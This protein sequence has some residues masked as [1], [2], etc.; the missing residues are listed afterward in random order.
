M[1]EDVKVVVSLLQCSV[2]LRVGPESGAWEVVEQDLVVLDMLLNLEELLVVHNVGIAHLVGLV[3]GHVLRCRTSRV[4]LC[5]GC[6]RAA[7]TG[8]LGDNICCKL[9]SEG[10]WVLVL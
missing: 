10:L 5:V 2:F 9:G 7:T 8:S 3:L 1:Y 6:G 4:A